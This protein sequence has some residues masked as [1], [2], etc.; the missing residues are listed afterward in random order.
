MSVKISLT[1][2]IMRQR[3][4]YTMSMNLIHTTFACEGSIDTGSLLARP[5]DR[6]FVWPPKISST[7][8]AQLSFITYNMYCKIMSHFAMMIKVIKILVDL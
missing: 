6:A 7:I 8:T 3:S 4:K 5:G 2:Q 1:A